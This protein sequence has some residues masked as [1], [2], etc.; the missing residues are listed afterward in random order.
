VYLYID[1]RPAGDQQLEAAGTAVL[2]YDDGRVCSRL[3]G[4]SGHF[5]FIL[6]QIKPGSDYKL[7]HFAWFRDT[8]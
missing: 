4:K 1:H 8:F 7:T 2:L 3:G 6:S 5:P